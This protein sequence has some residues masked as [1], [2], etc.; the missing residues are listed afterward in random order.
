MGTTDEA[1]E[2]GADER[3][4]FATALER[5]ARDEERA[6]NA[7]AMIGLLDSPELSA[8][9]A[10]RLLD[11]SER[12]TAAALDRLTGPGVLEAVSPDRYRMDDEVRA[13]SAELAAE[14]LDDAERTAA[15]TRVLG[16]YVSVAWPTR[17]L[18]RP[19]IPNLPDVRPAGCPEHLREPAAGMAWLDSEHT[20]VVGVVRR[21]AAQP[22]VDPAV[23]QRLALGLMTFYATWLH[24][25]DWIEVVEA[26]L[27]A[28][29][30]TG[31]AAAWLLDDLALAYSGVGEHSRAV[32]S[33]RRALELFEELGDLRGQASSCTCLSLVLGRLERD[34]ESLSYCRRSLAIS[35]DLGDWRAEAAACRDLG[36]LLWKAGDR[37]EALRYERRSLALYEHLGI[38]RGIGMAAVNTGS[39]LR[40]LGRYDEALE[41]LTR[42]VTVCRAVGDRA[43]EAEALEELGF[44]YAE[45]G[46]FPEGLT[47]LEDGLAL[48]D[49]TSDPRRRASVR[50]RIGLAMARAGRRD[51]AAAHWTAAL[52]ISE[53]HGDHQGAAEL[54]RLLADRRTD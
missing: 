47:L 30:R 49:D 1:S 7:V 23:L 54:R 53:D 40:E 50:H 48:A 6:A 15:L 21:A 33:A 25:R 36:L 31:V 29:G 28:G 19:G 20:T 51:E 16:L 37:E 24:L 13:Y 34:E 39:M 11:L 41:H 26:A 4:A 3:A 2:L 27:D 22:G 5:L 52:T 42:S 44:L 8:L 10:V 46:R 18:S 32:D 12:D 17:S 9:T 14:R 43:G 45:L 38:Q 35:R